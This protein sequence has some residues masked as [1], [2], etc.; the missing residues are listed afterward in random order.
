ME[1][2]ADP[3]GSLDDANRANNRVAQ[4]MTVS[5][6]AGPDFIGSG[7]AILFMPTYR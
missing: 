1:V 7:K 3:N 2:V 4:A 5:V 6:R